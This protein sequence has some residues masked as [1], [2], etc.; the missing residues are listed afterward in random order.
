MRFIILVLLSFISINIC[1][2]GKVYVFRN[3]EGVLVFSDAPQSNKAEEIKLTTK[4]T[5]IPSENTDV[6]NPVSESQHQIH[7]RF[8]INITQPSHESTVRDNTGSVYVS[9][10][11]SP[12][13]EPGHQ[14]RI[15]LNGK[16]QGKNLGRA[17]QI[18][19]NVN[20]GEHKLKMELLDK[21][22]KVIASSEEVTFFMHR[23][24][25]N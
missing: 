23:S 15:L 1:Y 12:N 4:P 13:F 9:G 5:V 18:L 19:R 22:G 11:I 20:R 17:T 7:T 2:A 16:Q 24:S 3:A 25:V 8:A 10:G 14:V 21:T 6:L